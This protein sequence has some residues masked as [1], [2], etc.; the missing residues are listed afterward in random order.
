MSP[1]EP[2]RLTQQVVGLLFGE[3][4]GGRLL[5]A[6]ENRFGTQP[7]RARIIGG[8]VLGEMTNDEIAARHN[9]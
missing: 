3:N 2:S 6:A 1:A 4:V 9:R 7:W 5:L 8:Q